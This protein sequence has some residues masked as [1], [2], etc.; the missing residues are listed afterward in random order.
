MALC[1]LVATCFSW[2]KLFFSDRYFTS[3]RSSFFRLRIRPPAPWTKATCNRLFI[4]KSS[5]KSV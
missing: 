4:Q 1:F 2:Y 3:F 5:Y